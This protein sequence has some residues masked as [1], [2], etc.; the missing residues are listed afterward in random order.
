MLGMK[1]GQKYDISSVYSFCNIDMERFHFACQ[2]FFFFFF[3]FFNFLFFLRR[4]N[5]VTTGHM[6]QIN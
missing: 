1:K 3:F 4:C 2:V 5:E 6:A